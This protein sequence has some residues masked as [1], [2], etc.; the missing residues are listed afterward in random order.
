MP[1]SDSTKAGSTMWW[2]ASASV[3]LAADLPMGVENPMGNQ[4]N[5][6]E[7]IISAK[8]AIQNVGVDA[9]KKQYA[10][11]HLSIGLPAHVPAATPAANP[12]MPEISHAAPMSA[13]DVS[14]RFA[15]TVVTGALKRRDVPASPCNKL[16]SQDIYRSK[17]GVSV[18]HQLFSWANLSSDILASAA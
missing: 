7:K 3:T 11:T 13:K 9:S 8:R 4:P 5:C 16:T 12:K 15:I 6:T 2:A 1:V 14:A 10:C 17:N 18:P